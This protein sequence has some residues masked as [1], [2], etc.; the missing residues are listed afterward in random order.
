MS[1]LIANPPLVRTTPP[2]DPAPLGTLQAGEF[3]PV[4]DLAKLRAALVADGT[5]TVGRLE[6]AATEALAMTVDQLTAW[7]ATQQAAGHATL[8]AVPCAKINGEPM[9]V[10]RFRRAVYAY[11]MASLLTRYASTSATGRSDDAADLRDTQAEQHARDG[12]WAVRDIAGTGRM[13]CELI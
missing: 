11:T 8:A 4:I 7:A 1:S 10:Q 2:D 6:H 3:W 13:A 5:A 12:I 9:H